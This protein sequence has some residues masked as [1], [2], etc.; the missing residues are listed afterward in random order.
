MAPIVFSE[1]AMSPSV[2]DEIASL[3]GGRS[4]IARLVGVRPPS[5]YCWTRVPAEHVLLLEEAVK[6]RI[7]RH[8]MRP[9]VFGLDPVSCQR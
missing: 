1:I 8:Q 3:L 2:V 6:G 5:V 4:E 9:D 7:S